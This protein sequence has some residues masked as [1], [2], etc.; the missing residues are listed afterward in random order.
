MNY[1]YRYYPIDYFFKSL[2]RNQLTKF[3]LWTCTHHFDLS[4]VSYQNT[5]LFKKKI[6]E[7]GLESICL[8][9]EQSNPKPYNLAG[10]D[11]FLKK[12][13]KLYFENAIRVANELEIPIISLNAGWD[14]YSENPHEAWM[15]STEMMHDLATFAKKKGI[16]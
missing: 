3:E 7:Y 8:T 10:K 12:K 4:D 6:K 14:Y 1:Y 16:K 5:K 15:R 9:P 13:T 11:K 2:Q